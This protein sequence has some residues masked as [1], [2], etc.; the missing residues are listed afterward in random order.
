[1]KCSTV[2]NEACL[3]VYRCTESPWNSIMASQWLFKDHQ[4]K[5]TLCQY[6]RKGFLSAHPDLK[7]SHLLHVSLVFIIW[8]L[9]QSG[10][11]TQCRH[12]S[13][14]AFYSVWHSRQHSVPALVYIVRFP[15]Q[16]SVTVIIFSMRKDRNEQ[17]ASSVQGLHCYLL[18]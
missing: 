3:M 17:N 9:R 2:Q 1:M 14:A 8:W 15:L 4:W 7:V 16:V 6:L 11:S 10:R 12:R 18:I 13:D 5:Y